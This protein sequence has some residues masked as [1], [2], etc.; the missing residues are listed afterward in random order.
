MRRTP[1]V[2]GSLA[3]AARRW[4]RETDSSS[5]WSVSGEMVEV[6]MR[7]WWLAACLA[8]GGAEA[9]EAGDRGA[10]AMVRLEDMEAQACLFGGALDIVLLMLS[11][12]VLEPVGAWEGATLARA[13]DRLLLTLG[14]DVLQMDG[15]NSVRILGG[16]AEAGACTEATW[17][18]QDAFALAV[19]GDPDD[20]A[21][22]IRETL[23]ERVAKR[24]E[25][26]RE[27]Q[28]QAALAEAQAGLAMEEAEE[29]L[30]LS[31][32]EVGAAV[33]AE[34]ARAVAAEIA[35]A[36]ARQETEAEIAR[37]QGAVES[38]CIQAVEPAL[39]RMLE[40]VEHPTFAASLF[41]R[42]QRQAYAEETAARLQEVLTTCGLG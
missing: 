18:V 17:V 27:R 3:G 39:R 30:L 21:G 4:G 32:R 19:G 10:E 31:Q 15:S 23:W 29:R 37:M 26:A 35:A 41:S 6:N 38:G 28:R 8:A 34:R 13:G 22:A 40:E 1:G 36:R 5:R 14:T 33:R 16:E 9:Q 24:E 42:P 2:P 20:A 12:G 7:A 11:D 25:D